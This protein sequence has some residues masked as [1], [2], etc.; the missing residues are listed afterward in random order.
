MLGLATAA[1]LLVSCAEP[2]ALRLSVHRSALLGEYADRPLWIWTVGAGGVVAVEASLDGA[3]YRSLHPSAR[4]FR[5]PRPL[6]PGTHRLT[7]RVI[8]AG[9][10]PAA[11]EASAVAR[12]KALPGQRPVPG[13]PCYPAGP[14]PLRCGAGAL[15]SGQWPL[16]QIRL[17][18]LW[19]ALA[20][21]VLRGP[22]PVVVA[23]LDT[24]YVRHPDLIGNLDVAAGY[25]FVRDPYAAGDGDGIDPDATEPGPDGSGHG[26]A[27]A[28]VIAAGAD[29]GMGVA[30]MGWPW[31]R[32]RV[33]I[34]PVRVVGR[35]EATTYDLAQGLLYAAGLENVSGALPPR[36]AKIINLSLAEAARGPVDE[37]LEDALRRVTAAGAI[38]VAAAGNHG[39]AVGAPANS[40]HTVAVGSV[41][42]NG[43]RAAT[44]NFGPELDVAAPG[45]DHARQIPTLGVDRGGEAWRGIV[46]PDRGTSIAA[47]HVSGALALL[48]GHHRSLT[49]SDARTLLA[50]T[51][52]DLGAPGR[53]H[54]FGHGLLDA[55]T[56][57]DAD[58]G[59][60]SV[61]TGRF[62]R[63]P[64]G[65]GAEA[66]GIATPGTA[67]PYSLIVRFRD[68][69][70][71][72]S[73]AGAAGERTRARIRARIRVRH[74]VAIDAGAGG[75]ALVRLREGQ[76][77]ERV[78]ARLHAD[79]AVAAVYDNRI[80]E[81]ASGQ[82]E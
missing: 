15:D 73:A 29:N 42:A 26:T 65:H 51:A 80:Y 3:P 31:G 2:I 72:Q 35:R 5:P 58:T 57:F 8:A 12:V 77:R 30:G 14:D 71:N 53:D 61:R 9:A 50:D 44:S 10:F 24:G 74:A 55:F 40:P 11:Q 16:R 45:G 18:E 48:A 43:S 46:R 33:T 20:A 76:D 13:D 49:L 7:V 34:M 66:P 39:S 22:E 64:A 67:D 59:R 75:Y 69:G 56:L 17:P 6:A 60:R 52:V 79:S 63:G 1:A 68:D 36:P 82:G 47:A 78:K 19:Q 27:I 32:S 37:V 41:S 38:V 62:P 21:R 28:G 4:S 25:D 70:M 81:P 54:H 23:V